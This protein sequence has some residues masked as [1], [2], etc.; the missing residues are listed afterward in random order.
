MTEVLQQEILNRQRLEQDMRLLELNIEAERREQIEHNEEQE[1]QRRQLQHAIELELQNNQELIQKLEDEVKLRQEETQQRYQLEVQ[2][3]EEIKIKHELEIEF[4]Q[5]DLQS[6]ML[7]QEL[8]QQ[9][10]EMQRL[11]NSDENKDIEVVSI[12]DKKETNSTEYSAC[13][14]N[15]DAS[16]NEELFDKGK[17]SEDGDVNDIEN[18]NSNDGTS[19]EDEKQEIQR[20]LLEEFQRLESRQDHEKLPTRS[21]TVSMTD[22]NDRLK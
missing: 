19:D 8:R 10:R 6:Q 20:L 4:K 12:N 14:S 5:A 1:I 17:G 9:L 7:E 18:D 21:I 16:S 13:D 22:K 15:S 2:L 11:F 3:Q